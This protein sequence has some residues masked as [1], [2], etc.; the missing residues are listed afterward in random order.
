MHKNG[1]NGNIG[2]RG[3]TTWKQNIQWKMLPTVG[4]EPRPLITSDSKSNTI[5]SGLTWYMLIRRSLNFC[6][7]SSWFLDLATINRAWLYKKGGLDHW[8]FYFHIKP[9]MSILALLPTLF[10]YEKTRMVSQE[11]SLYGAAGSLTRNLF[12]VLGVSPFWWSFYFLMLQE[13]SEG[14][15]SDTGSLVRLR[16]L[17]RCLPLRD[18]AERNVHR[19]NHRKQRHSGTSHNRTS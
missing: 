13:V 10:I 19:R 2:I 7:C 4:T 1:N 5:L 18:R 17:C 6:S 15:R 9:L 11:V 12:L 14:T 8:I 16:D 3:F